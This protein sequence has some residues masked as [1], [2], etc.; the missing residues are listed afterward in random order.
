MPSYC[1]HEHV[2]MCAPREYSA[3]ARDALV[4]GS[5]GPDALYYH[6]PLSQ[7]D[8]SNIGQRLHS[9]RTNDFLLRLI[10][11]AGESLDAR[12]YTLGFISHYATD[13]VFH[14]FVYALSMKGQSYSGLK[15]LEV[16]Q[17]LD[18]WLADT[19]REGRRRDKPADSALNAAAACFCAAAAQWD[20]SIQLEPQYAVQAFRLCAS[21]NGLMGRF[22]ELQPL[23]KLM[24]NSRLQ[25]VSPGEMQAFALR[26]WKHPWT[27]E[28][29]YEGPFELLGQSVEFAQR[30]M[31]LAE[32]CWRGEDD[33][34]EFAETAGDRSYLSG[35][36]WRSSEKLHPYEIDRLRQFKRSLFGK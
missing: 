12:A 21:M 6:D 31:A 8:L 32:S 9:T 26:G 20:S 36:D 13:V 17:A 1:I 16:E 30:L 27:G 14:P 34:F 5:Y 33:C 22:G 28:T 10:A 4:I 25:L 35:I 3:G 7:G 19:L 23:L 2:A 24:E 11:A 18:K 29:R 15:H